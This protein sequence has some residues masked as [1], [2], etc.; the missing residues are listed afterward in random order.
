M[1]TE[2][3]QQA[4]RGWGIRSGLKGFSCPALPCQVLL[5]VRQMAV[6]C[7]LWAEAPLPSQLLAC[8]L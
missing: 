4:G 7:L 8:R 6:P 2:E 3:K 5:V 1:N